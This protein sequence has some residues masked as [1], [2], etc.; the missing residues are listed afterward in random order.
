M[1][2]SRSWSP[3]CA[4]RLLYSGLAT[5]YLDQ[6]PELSTFTQYEYRLTA[7]NSRG[8]TSSEW[9][10]VHTAESTPQHVSPPTVVVRTLPCAASPYQSIRFVLIAKLIQGSW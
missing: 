3:V 2:A 1:S 10:R 9:R 6:S 5:E 7:V 8:Q 4:G